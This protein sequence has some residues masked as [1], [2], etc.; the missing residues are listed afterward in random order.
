[1]FDVIG[2]TEKST[3]LFTKHGQVTSN[4]RTYKN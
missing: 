4:P 1:M 2:L 3:D